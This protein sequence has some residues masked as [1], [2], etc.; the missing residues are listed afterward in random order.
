M[1][2]TIQCKLPFPEDRTTSQEVMVPQMY[3]EPEFL[4]SEIE[5]SYN[6]GAHH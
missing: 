6:P 5:I 1:K 3:I 4:V 2:K